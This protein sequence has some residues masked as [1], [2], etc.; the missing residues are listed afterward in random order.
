MRAARS[1]L[2]TARR[3][4]Y[5]PISLERRVPDGGSIACADK[6]LRAS[7]RCNARQAAA[8]SGRCSTRQAA[9]RVEEDGGAGEVGGGRGM[10]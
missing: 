2:P 1:S 3:Q 9:A 10:R 6:Q 5:E 7:G 8:A 4:A